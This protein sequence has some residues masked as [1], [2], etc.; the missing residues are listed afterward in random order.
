MTGSGPEPLII[1]LI[2][3]K[4][5]WPD[6]GRGWKTIASSLPKRLQLGN[7]WRAEIVACLALEGRYRAARRARGGQQ[8]EQS[9]PAASRQAAQPAAGKFSPIRTM[10]TPKGGEAGRDC[11]CRSRPPIWLPV[12]AYPGGGCFERWLQVQEAISYAATRLVREFGNSPLIDEHYLSAIAAPIAAAWAR[13]ATGA[14]VQAARFA[15]RSAAGT[16][17]RGN[18]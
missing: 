12:D 7:A 14:E 10:A 4:A 17:H 3:W 9:T 8:P 15:W 5:I 6:Q 1:L 11:R 18:R 16:R 2:G 13:S